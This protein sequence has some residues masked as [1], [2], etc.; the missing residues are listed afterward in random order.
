VT[1]E[2]PGHW[3]SSPRELGG[4]GVSPVAPRAPGQD[5]RATRRGACRAGRPA[6]SRG[7]FTL[8]EL[9]IVVLIVG[10]MAAA[11]A[12][13]LI[14]SVCYHRAEAAARRVKLDLDLARRSAR[15]SSA[16]RSIEFDT[17]AATYTLAGT[18]HLDHQ[19]ADYSVRLG[20]APYHAAIVSADFDG[21]A[22]LTFNGYGAAD[23]AG[24]VVVQAG[25]YQR[26]ITVEPT[27]GKASIE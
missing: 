8:V 16:D 9:V 6:G 13:R 27:T 12:P 15:L 21:G 1:V 20:Q 17:G 19:G 5:A 23:S 14:D 11:A 25:P 4:T 3:Q 18:T 24:S 26:T 22:V 2:I 7:A 10:I